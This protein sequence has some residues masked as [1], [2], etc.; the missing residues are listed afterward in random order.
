MRLVFVMQAGRFVQLT[1]SRG[2]KVLVRGEW[3]EYLQ[4]ANGAGHMSIG[5]AF[6]GVPT[7]QPPRLPSSAVR[8]H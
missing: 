4:H 5:A 8:Q 7:L 6:R 3:R 1:S 2:A